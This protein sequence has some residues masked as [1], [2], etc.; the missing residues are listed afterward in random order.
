MVHQAAELGKQQRKR[1]GKAGVS[2]SN[3][4]GTANGVYLAS[5][6]HSEDLVRDGGITLRRPCFVSVGARTFVTRMHPPIYRI[7]SR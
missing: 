6:E 7:R 3:G 4:N 2:N 1:D 5:S